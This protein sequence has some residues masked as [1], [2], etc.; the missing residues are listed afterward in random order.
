MQRHAARAV[1][2]DLEP[3]LLDDPARTRVQ[4]L[5]RSR[6]S[7]RRQH[8]ALV[9]LDQGGRLVAG[10]RQVSNRA[11]GIVAIIA[12]IGVEQHVAAR[13]ALLHLDDFLALDIQGAGH[14]IDL[15]RG[16]R[17]AVGCHVGVVFEALLHGAQIEKQLALR[18]GRGH[19]DHTPVLQNIFV[20]LGLDPVHRIAHQTHVLVRVKALDRLHETNVAFLNQI[21][22]RQSI[23][24]VLA[25]HRHHQPQVREHQLAGGIKVVFF[26]ELAAKLL[27]FSQSEHGQPVDG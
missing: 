10:V 6:D 26:L 2:L 8:V 21:A 14:R 3:A 1:V 12:R 27:L 16:E 20:Y 23:T 22:V 19:L 18:L 11:K 13:H 17:V 25:R 24:E 5:Q 4:F 15:V 7:V 9:R